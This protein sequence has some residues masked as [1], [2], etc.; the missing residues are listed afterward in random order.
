MICSN[1]FTE[2]RATASFCAKCQTALHFC[3]S[4]NQ[5]LRAGAKFC[6]RCGQQ[7]AVICE[8]CGSSNR[9]EANFCYDCQQSLTV[10]A[11]RHCSDI[12]R[13]TAVFC[14]QCGL[15]VKK[16]AVAMPSETACVHCGGSN[17]KTARF[18]LHCGQAPTKSARSRYKTGQLPSQSIMY[19]S[20]GDEYLISK[21]IAQGGMGAVYRAVQATDRTIWAIKEMSESAFASGEKEQMI[22]AFQEEAQLLQ[23]LEHDNLPNVIDVFENNDSHYMVM[24][25]VDGLTFTEL[26]GQQGGVLSEA[27]IIAWGAQLCVV[28]DY[29]HN[30][31]PP[32]IYR[33]LKPEN[34]MVET[35]GDVVKLIDFGIARRFKP[36]KK[37]DTTNLGTKGYAPP[38]QYGK[39][40]QQ[41][42]ARTDIYALGATLHHMLTGR[43]PVDSLFHFSDIQE[44]ITAVSQSTSNA[45]LKAVK[46][47][48]SQRHQSAADMY[49]ALTGNTMSAQ[50]KPQK[51]KLMSVSLP[52][53]QSIQF[54]NMAQ[55]SSETKYLPIS[56]TTGELS[57]TA[58]VN[59]L[60]V[61]PVKVDSSIT[62][63]EITAVTHDLTIGR[64]R[65]DVTYAPFFVVDYLWWGFIRLLYAHAYYLVPV[66]ETHQGKVEVGSHVVDVSVTISPSP[67]RLST[68]WVLSTTAVIS[69]IGVIGGII[70]G[71][72]L[73]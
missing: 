40:G 56:I 69:E 48:P 50:S 44:H 26:M 24:D 27:D 19:G 42:D 21:L 32:I 11:C 55:G 46:L 43:D 3:L 52:V 64:E 41:S 7:T 36:K 4:C 54:D 72:L 33:D 57:V 18:C 28:L 61:Y 51:N 63:I 30:H 16:T 45:I 38:E 23:T 73:L 70:F 6:L 60:D 34:I 68:G 14:K 58:D 67:F 8:N 25:F 66:P 39:S 17:R 59:W 62:D 10:T 53:D 65:R 49:K 1:C 2:N 13:K 9:A 35:D 71:V 47:K 22:A 20:T 12:N 5:E 31:N 15:T 29:L 37:G